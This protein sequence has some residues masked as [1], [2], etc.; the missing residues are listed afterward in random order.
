MV[1]VNHACCTL[2]M[3]DIILEEKEYSYKLDLSRT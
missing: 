3:L 2:T 1:K